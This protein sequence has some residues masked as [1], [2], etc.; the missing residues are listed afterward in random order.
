MADNSCVFV[1]DDCRTWGENGLCLTCYKGY[2]LQSG[3]CVRSQISSRDLDI[4]CR[5]WDWDNQI[6]LKCSERWV[7]GPSGC[8]PISDFCQTFNSDG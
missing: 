7:M 3:I 2:E 4:G 6:C 5:E 8:I 1:S